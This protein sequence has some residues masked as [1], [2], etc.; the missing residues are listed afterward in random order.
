MLDLFSTLML[1]CSKRKKSARVQDGDGHM[2]NA[3]ELFLS[4]DPLSE[5]EESVT[6]DMFSQEHTRGGLA[7]KYLLE[8]KITVNPRRCLLFF[9]P[10]VASTAEQ[11]ILTPDR[12]KWDLYLVII[13]FTL[14]ET[15]AHA[16]YQEV[17]FL[18][19]L[20]DPEATAFDL[21]P[22]NITTEG[23]EGQ[24][25]VLSPDI[26]IHE[27]Q[28]GLGQ[29]GKHI[30]FASLHPTISAFGEGQSRFYWKYQGFGKQKA[31]TPET[32]QALVVLQV[33]RG[34][35]FV[36]GTISY[37]VV[38]AQRLYGAWRWE[39]CS[40]EPYTLHWELREALP[41]FETPTIRVSK[42]APERTS[43]VDVCIVSG[44][45][46]EAKIFMKEVSRQCGAT[47]QQAFS[48]QTRRAYYQTTIPNNRGEPLTL[49]VSWQP[50]YGPV[51]AGLHIKPLLEEFRPRFAAMTGICAGDKRKVELGDIIVAER[52]FSYDTG[53]IILGEDGRQEHLHDVDVY[54]PHPDVLH[55]VRLFGSSISALAD[56]PPPHSKRQPKIHIAPMASGSAV[57]ADHPFDDVM[58]PV[59]GTVAIDMEGATFYRTATEFP[60]IRSLL[61]KGVC[62]YADGDKDDSYHE[63]AAAVSATYLA[64]FIKEYVNA[65]LMPRLR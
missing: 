39:D 51:E 29:P 43:T 13:P 23:A 59:R 50:T 64:H 17:T 19:E 49:L 7:Q 63:Y 34:T 36:D 65:E 35:P 16:Y 14:H 47:F 30:R 37:E 8:G 46:E 52:A 1:L 10:P 2:Q 15:P 40:T 61:V 20:A 53:K 21:F 12:T 41:L 44:M 18:V 33:P 3:D 32:K 4:N 56:L 11:P 58:I 60:E 26:K 48:P 9:I 55:W 6:L 27:S 28:T 62:D 24:S 42:S 57:R 54:R 31:V 22:R 38:L 45:G 25:Y 5:S